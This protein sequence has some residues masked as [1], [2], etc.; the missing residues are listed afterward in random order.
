MKKIILI[1]SLISVK[2]SAG[3]HYDPNYY[4]TFNDKYA[5][6]QYHIWKNGKPANGDIAVCPVKM[7]EYVQSQNHKYGINVGG[8]V[9]DT[10]YQGMFFK[11]T[12][13]INGK[14]K[15]VGEKNGEIRY[16][17]CN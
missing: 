11:N 2:A 1:I 5:C 3:C 15:N 7:S 17:I 12:R 16:A 6:E 14:F 4:A 8:V 10:T 9:D 13:S